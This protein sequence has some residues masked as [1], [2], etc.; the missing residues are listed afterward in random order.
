VRSIATRAV[1]EVLAVVLAGVA[2]LIGWATTVLVGI[3]ADIVGVVFYAPADYV[4]QDAWMI[5]SVVVAAGIAGA[6]WR[7]TRQAGGH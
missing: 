6:T 4:H 7:L 1:R 5:G 2:G 3:S